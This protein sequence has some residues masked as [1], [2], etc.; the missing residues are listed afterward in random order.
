MTSNVLAVV[1]SSGQVAEA[2]KR[3]A[4]QRGL[5]AHVRG[6]PEADLGVAASLERYLDETRPTVVINAAAYTAVDQAEREPDLAFAINAR[7]PGDL[8]RLCAERDLPLIHLSS[9]YVF[10]G[11]KTSPYLEDDAV[12][13]VSVYGASKAAGDDEI[14]AALKM[15]VIIRTAWVYGL[16]GR[17]FVKT[18]MRL[19]Q[20]R[21]EL[22]VVSD[23]HGCP[24]FADDIASAVLDITA[25]LVPDAHGCWGTFH[26]TNSGETTWHDFARQIFDHMAKA[27]MNTPRLKPIG[28]DQYPTPAR[29]PAYSVLDCTKI[30]RVFGVHPASWTDALGRAMPRLLS[31][32]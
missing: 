7:G 8:A 5:C 10:D 2:L 19:A 22:S 17:N 1:G 13:P 20:E 12:A 27:G 15:H 30:G 23:Q 21:D 26:L 6:R 25:Q 16:E 24:T 31:A 14:R 28:T 18:M 32:T 29:R 4:A 11:T 3:A 9:D